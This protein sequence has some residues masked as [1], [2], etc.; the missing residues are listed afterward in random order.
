MSC[1]GGHLRLTT[2]KQD[3]HRVYT[4]FEH[5]HWLLILQLLADQKVWTD[6]RDGYG[7]CG[8]IFRTFGCHPG[9]QPHKGTGKNWPLHALIVWTNYARKLCRQNWASTRM[10]ATECWDPPSCAQQWKRKGWQKNQRKEGP[11][12]GIQHRTENYFSCTFNHPKSRGQLEQ[13]CKS[14]MWHFYLILAHLHT[15]Q[16]VTIRN[17]QEIL[18]SKCHFSWTAPRVVGESKFISTLYLY[19][20]IYIYISIYTYAYMYMIYIC[21]CVCYWCC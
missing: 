14:A 11:N 3:I 21:V 16:Y 10:S 20:H 12:L 18:L 6:G 5:I 13:C 15:W 9:T 17:M 4:G 1:R 2:L 7:Y 8:R 19:I